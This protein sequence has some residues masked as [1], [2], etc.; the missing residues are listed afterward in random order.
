M[1]RIR[2]ILHRLFRRPAI[3]QPFPIYL[4]RVP[5]GV[6]LDLEAYFEHVIT[7]IADDPDLLDLLLEF[8]ED[9]GT[10]G[11]YDGHA[12]EKLL[13]ERLGSAV[14]YEIPLYGD[15]AAKF[16]D[17]LRAAAPAPAVVVP[18]QREGGAAA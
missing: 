16:A 9:R 5:V 4:R 2:L 12:P 6:F 1:N 10:S 8:A 15:K 17:R 14:G 11:Q 18:A 3:T 13:V 7:T